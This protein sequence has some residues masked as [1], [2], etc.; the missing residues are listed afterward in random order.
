MAQP[1]SASQSGRL[2]VVC[3][4]GRVRDEPGGGRRAAEEE[5]AERLRELL[6]VHRPALLSFVVGIVHDRGLAED[7][8]Q[9]TMIRAWRTAEYL[10]PSVGSVRGW[11]F[12]VARN[13]AVDQFR[14]RRCRPVEVAETAAAEVTCG[15][16]EAD[17]LLAVLEVR[18]GLRRLSPVQLA[19]VHECYYNG[20]T[21][22]E[23]AVVLGVP[24]G[25]VKSR[26]SCALHRLRMLLG[27][28]AG[29]PRLA[30]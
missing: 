16:D 15:E 22:A 20:R 29:Q 18:R 11:L 9:E 17:R 3:C 5:I 14:A 24:V 28:P 8:V 21:A 30:A 25:T 27:E 1:Q 7:V 26:L 12:R 4:E 6:A 23:A 19:A 2:V 10:S 13:I